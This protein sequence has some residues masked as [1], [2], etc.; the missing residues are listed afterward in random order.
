MRPG[1]TATTLSLP[2]GPTRLEG[3][4]ALPAGGNALPGRAF[5]DGAIAR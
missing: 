5:A 3:T 2:V 1:A 4:L